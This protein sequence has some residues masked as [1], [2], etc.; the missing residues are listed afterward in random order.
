M[1]VWVSEYNVP[2][3]T[4]TVSGGQYSVKTFK[5][6]GAFAGKTLIF[7]VADKDTGAT[8]IWESGMATVLDL[9]VD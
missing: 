2:V 5:Y 6:G 4:G 7:K 1:N 3:G 9:P 8:V